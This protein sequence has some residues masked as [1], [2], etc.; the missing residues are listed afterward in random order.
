MQR[1]TLPPFQGI[2]RNPSTS[3][4]DSQLI[5]GE[6]IVCRKGQTYVRPGCSRFGT[7][8]NGKILG[9]STYKELTANTYALVAWTLTDA[10]YYD[11]VAD[12]CK[13]ATP[14]HTTGT[15]TSVSGGGVV[16]GNATAWL[17]GWPNGLY[18]IRFGTHDP[19]AAV[20]G[21]VTGWYT[22]SSFTS[23][24]GCQLSGV[25]FPT[26]SAGALYVIRKC[27]TA[28]EAD[29]IS[30]CE[31]IDSNTGDKVLVWS[32]WQDQVQFWNGAVN[33][34]LVAGAVYR[35]KFVAYIYD[36]L[37]LGF[38]DDDG[39]RWP[40]SVWWSARGNI[41]DFTS[42]AADQ[43]GEDLKQDPNWLTGIM[44]FRTHVV[45]YKD[46]SVIDGEPTGNV[47]PAFSFYEDA[48]LK[49]PLTWRTVRPI[50]GMY[51]LFLAGDGNVYAHTTSE[52]TPV[53]DDVTKEIVSLMNLS[54]TRHS[55]AIVRPE[56]GLYLLFIPTGSSQNPNTVYVYST[57]EKHWVRWT[58]PV[59]FTAG[60]FHEFPGSGT[61][62]R[63]NEIP[64][65]VKWK[66]AQ[67][68]LSQP[69]D[70]EYPV[71][72]TGDEDGYLYRHRISDLTDNGVAISAWL[73]TKDYL[74]DGAAAFMALESRMTL[75]E[76][77]DGIIKASAS[78]D[79]GEHWTAPI[80]VPI[81][82][83]NNMNPFKIKWNLRGNGVRVRIENLNG[84]RFII[85][86]MSLGVERAGEV[87]G[88]RQ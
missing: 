72:V 11:P 29:Y 59:K 65:G 12:V 9:V 10:Y 85:N 21:S 40:Q 86:Q 48:L 81:G 60:C 53:G 46:T 22:V 30:S 15:I 54:R 82:S 24:T 37:L 3:V 70:A 31:A 19:D 43:G 52:M 75:D 47:E 26:V 62:L 41:R 63:F 88:K 77:S 20:G 18:Q 17:T 5:D 8:L 78:V 56:L 44:P 55:W 28:T 45:G 1:I 39:E 16:V 6:N 68:D 76:A 14:L 87:V 69:V 49:G 25:S 67:Y 57:E 23:A 80:S 74:Y 71:L 83:V 51:H 79:E 36:H 2:V 27:Y 32:N 50:E 84:S 7:K 64:V 33:D 4:K 35:A 61:P 73:E 13:F 58:Y 66:D 42:W 38:I 34:A